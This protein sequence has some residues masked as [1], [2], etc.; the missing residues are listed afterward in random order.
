MEN[1][2]GRGWYFYCCLVSVS[3]IIDLRGVRELGKGW[4]ELMVPLWQVGLECNHLSK[5]SFGM[6]WWGVTNQVS[7][8]KWWMYKRKE[9]AHNI[10]T[11]KYYSVMMVALKKLCA[12]YYHTQTTCL[13]CNFNK[14]DLLRSFHANFHKLWG[15]AS[16]SWEWMFF[17]H[18]TYIR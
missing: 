8:F 17:Y 11:Y 15:R 16:P 18:C 14:K 13:R 12:L 4:G 9:R 1:L 6:G 7:V 5:L 10:Q 3:L 2:G